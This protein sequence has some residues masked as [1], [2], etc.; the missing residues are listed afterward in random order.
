LPLAI[1]WSPELVLAIAGLATAIG[2]IVSSITGVIMNRRAMKD[3]TD[4]ELRDKLRATRAEAEKYAQ[5]LHEL[6]M[7]ELADES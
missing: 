5:E 7:K 3:E 2:G 6:R 4:K 1:E